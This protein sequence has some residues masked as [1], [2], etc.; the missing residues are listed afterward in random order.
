MPDFDV[1]KFEPFYQAAKNNTIVL[2]LLKW[3]V[4][5]R[6]Q[7]I[8]TDFDYDFTLDCSFEDK[9]STMTVEFQSLLN[10]YNQLMP[11]IRIIDVNI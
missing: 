5:L 10:D 2:T 4:L 8:N 11:Q 3:S 7:F 9:P 6:G 1:L